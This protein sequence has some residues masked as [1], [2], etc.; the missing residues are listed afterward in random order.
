MYYCTSLGVDGIKIPL[1]LGEI[2]RNHL[3]LGWKNSK[4]LHCNLS[5]V[6]FLI[7]IHIIS[8][9]IYALRIKNLRICRFW[10]K[11][12]AFLTTH[13]FS[14]AQSMEH[15][16]SCLLIILI[17]ICHHVW[18]PAIILYHHYISPISADYIPNS[19]DQ[20]YHLNF[21]SYPHSRSLKDHI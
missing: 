20:N 21:T 12:S 5:V 10:W 3:S 15:N 16:V 9:Y 14:K 11:T 4:P 13:V 1:F 2:C 6:G 19:D 7:H 18:L 17:V 8:I